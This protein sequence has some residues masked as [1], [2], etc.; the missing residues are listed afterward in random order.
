M[1]DLAPGTPSWMSPEQAA[2]RMDRIDIRT[3]VYSLGKILYQ[4]LTGQPPHRL[5]GTVRE[6]LYRIAN[7]EA[8]P[9][10]T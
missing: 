10:R 1:T 7:E 5:E 9:P 8:R 4:L 3:D 2:G 6:V